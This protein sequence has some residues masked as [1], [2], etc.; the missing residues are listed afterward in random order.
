VGKGGGL[1]G[2]LAK[3]PSPSSPRFRTDGGGIDR[4]AGRQGRPPAAPC[5]A[6]SGGW[7]K[8]ER[9]PRGS[10]PLPTLGCD[11]V[12]G[13]IGG[14][15]RRKVVPAMGGGALVL[16]QGREVAVVVRDA[17]GNGAGLLIAGVRRFEGGISLRRPAAAR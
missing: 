3:R 9:R 13:W 16:R 17:A 14:G 2:F 15:G 11:G 7:G 8:M 6:V 1:G 10:I 5:T 4:V 12:Q